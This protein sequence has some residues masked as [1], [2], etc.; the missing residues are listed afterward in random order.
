MQPQPV[1]D[2]ELTPEKNGYQPPPTEHQP[3]LQLKP[4]RQK[5][6]WLMVAVIA[7]ILGSATLISI[8]MRKAAPKIDIPKLTV[9][10][11]SKN[12][13]IQIVASGIV[14]PVQTVNLS[15]KTQGR[16]AELYVEQGERVQKGQIIA[17]MESSE[18][19]AQLMQ[20][21]ARLLSAKARLAKLQ[22]GNRA[23]EIA[24]ARA[25]LSQAEARLAQLRAG[26][27][28]EEIAQA[29]ARVEIART[30]LADAESGTLLNEI[31]QAQA[32]VESAKALAELMSSRVRR[33]QELRQQGAIAE[34]TF[35]EY[36][37][38]ERSAKASLQEAQK[39]LARAKENQQVEIARRRAALEI[40]Q[41]ALQQLK[42]GYRPEEIRK[43]EAE[44]AEAQSNLKLLQKGTRPEDI[45]QATAE[46][47]EA[48]AQVR[49][50][51]VLLE[52][53]KIRAP[54]SGIITQRY[55]TE[56]AFVTPATSASDASSAT[57]TSIVALAR[58]LEILAKVP[59]ADISQIKVSQEVEIIADAYPDKIFKGRV[60]LIAPEAIKERDVTLF[61][62]RVEIK[63]G[64][65]QLQSGMNVDL[66]FLGAQLNNA[67]VVPPGVIVT[68]KCNRG[69]KGV[70]VYEENK[71]KF[72]PVTIGSIIDNQI[73]ILSGLKPGE[74]VFAELPEGKNIEDILPKCK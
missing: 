73:Q 38:E 10:V 49:Y 47:A 2:K 70:L 68:D 50:Y 52:D 56:G 4:K 65:E 66:K 12:L 53:T 69:Q 16:L 62:V 41:Q 40:E 72:K 58:D 33:Y 61:Q 71:I 37:K 64:K 42:N 57:S 31:A 20:A 43:S 36:K 63:T 25:R 44:V 34:Y 7:T 74:R 29:Q 54:F 30:N 19:E 13:T 8:A 24:Q 60:R 6:H 26:S 17:R 27:R 59:E 51:Q 11:E 55:A 14:R 22:A 3:F 21:Q 5:K 48:E 1:S 18:I 39:R 9:P 35:E 67:L 32:Q 28:V 15:P 23:E 45:A 46:V